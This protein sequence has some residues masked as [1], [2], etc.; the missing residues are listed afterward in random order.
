MQNVLASGNVDTYNREYWRISP[1]RVSP[2]RRTRSSTWE[3]TVQTMQTLGVQRLSAPLSPA[4]NNDA[5]FDEI[6]WKM[7]IEPP[8]SCTRGEPT[9]ITWR[10]SDG[11]TDFAPLFV[12]IE[13]WNKAWN[14][15]T[16]IALTAPNTGHYMWPRVYWG[17]PIKDEY[18]IKIY[19]ADGEGPHELLAESR[20]FS[21]VK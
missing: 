7:E 3:D 15:P 1:L 17:M 19:G 14:V 10:M 9:E 8:Q 21:I 11:S 2:L 13:V 5:T 20:L 12:R 4:P 16:V 18:F 6:K